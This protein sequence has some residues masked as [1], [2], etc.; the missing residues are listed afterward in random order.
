[1]QHL[2]S[3]QRAERQAPSSIGMILVGGGYLILNVGMALLLGEWPFICLCAMLALNVLLFLAFQQKWSV[4]FYL[5]V[6]APSIAFPL[7]ESGIVSR[8][9]AGNLLFAL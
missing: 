3:F 5:L 6:A 1:M 9:F 4:P 2:V 7:G 8:L